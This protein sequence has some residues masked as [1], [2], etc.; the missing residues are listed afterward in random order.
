L[1]ISI[2]TT[3]PQALFPIV[4]IT[5]PRF[6]TFHPD[7]VGHYILYLT[8][9]PPLTE[10]YI[11]GPSKSSIQPSLKVALTKLEAIQS[12]VLEVEPESEG[13]SDKIIQSVPIPITPPTIS[14]RQRHQMH[15]RHNFQT[16]KP[17]ASRHRVSTK[18]K[19]S[20]RQQPKNV[21]EARKQ[22]ET[23]VNLPCFLVY[24]LMFCSL[25]FVL[26]FLSLLSVLFLFCLIRF[27]L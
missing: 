12:Q 2:H 25:L 1:P 9:G 14:H 6:S 8:N 23:T 4:T 13:D 5:A 26:I 22:K 20:T 16:H 7:T 11:A 27:A 3:L 24:F 10:C 15:V 19:K 18:R 17:G 21:D